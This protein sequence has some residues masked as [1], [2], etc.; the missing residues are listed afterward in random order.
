MEYTTK[1]IWDYLQRKVNTT[2]EIFKAFFGEERV[3]LQPTSMI[4]TYERQKVIIERYILT[5]SIEE[6]NNSDNSENFIVGKDEDGDTIYNISES[7]LERLDERY[8]KTQYSIYV[9][10]DKVKVTNEFDK[11]VF[12][13]DLY[14]KI[15]LTF[16]GTIPYESVGF[17]LNRATYPEI[18]FRSNY[19]HS[20][21]PA[22]PRTNFSS[23]ESPCLGRGPII[24]TIMTLK[25][26]YDETIWMLFCQELD[27]YVTVESIAGG[28]WH[29]LESIG[30]MTLNRTLGYG[31]TI[32]LSE[33]LQN[34]ADVIIVK[35]KRHLKDFI[36]YYLEKGHLSICYQY[37]QYTVG[38]PYYD[39]MVDI[40]NAFIE[41][42]NCTLSK[43][44]YSWE[45]LLERNILKKVIIKNGNFY[46]SRPSSS[47][48]SGNIQQYQNK[49]VL[50]F[51]G[52][53]IFTKILPQDKE[54]EDN[55]S[56]IIEHNLAMFLLDHIL[57]V[58]NYRYKN[59]H[60]NEHTE[61]GGED[62]STAHTR[63]F[64][65]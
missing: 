35:I 9:W 19:M 47:F 3:D 24:N 14:A 37:G 1:Q 17:Y 48:F 12:I 59:K 36:K 61:K 10:W 31:Y 45:M 15:P 2:Y 4:N 32:Y 57:K 34:P 38:T 28:P 11:F 60:A 63:V 21:I 25:S 5:Q 20:H 44:F 39:F 6:D 23:F 62:S 54:E 13:Q 43:N 53:G 64:Y 26:N 7:T 18:Q 56:L 42:Y 27:T 49:F 33:V 58:I 65:L 55:N 50:T 41:F 40:S 46:I 52:K 51:K 22:I 8:A 29:K 30:A 16:E